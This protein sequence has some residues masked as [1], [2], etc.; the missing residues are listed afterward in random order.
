MVHMPINQK[1]DALTNIKTAGA[2]IISGMTHPQE[3]PLPSVGISGPK[4]GG[5]V[6]SQALFYGDIP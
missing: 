3:L 4:N 1:L 2:S 6:P 5:T